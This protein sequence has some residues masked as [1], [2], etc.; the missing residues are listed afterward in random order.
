MITDDQKSTNSSTTKGAY[1]PKRNTNER[2]EIKIYSLSNI[3]IY[4]YFALQCIDK[5][6]LNLNSYL[7]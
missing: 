5:D 3:P 7:H 2:I 6:D 4:F 1:T